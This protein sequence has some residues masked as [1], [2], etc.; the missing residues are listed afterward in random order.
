[1]DNNINLTILNEAGKSAKMG[2]DSIT[3]I[4][5][6]VEDINMKKNLVNQ[7]NGYQ[8]FLKEIDSEFEKYGELPDDDKI[9]NK[10]MVWT[11]IQFN[12]MI[13]KSNSHIAE[14]MIQG[15]IMGVIECQKLLNHNPRSEESVKKIL[16]DFLIFQNNNIE[17]MKE[18]L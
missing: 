5:D 9:S 6:K 1:M 15:N 12:T 13:D 14:I 2:M 7:Y 18:F 4:T 16:T 3:Y 10:L 8:S 11:G 17:K